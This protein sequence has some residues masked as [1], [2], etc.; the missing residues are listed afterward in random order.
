[1]TKVLAV[2]FALLE[3]SLLAGMNQQWWKMGAGK[4]FLQKFQQ[5]LQDLHLPLFNVVYADADKHIMLSFNGIIPVRDKGDV[6]FWQAPV[7]G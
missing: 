5:I 7:P 3:T 4:T 1:M 6:T 2:R